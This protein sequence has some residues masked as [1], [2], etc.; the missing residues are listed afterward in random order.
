MDRAVLLIQCPDHKGIVA[1]ISNF[2]FGVDGNIIH[3]D[4]YSTDPEGGR[5]F[6][7]VEFDFDERRLSKETLESAFAPIAKDLEATW[8]IHYAS[9]PLRMG[10]LVSRYDH[11]LFEV[12]YRL[13][14]GDLHVEIPFVM[15]N[16]ADLADLVEGYGIPFHCVP[17]Q[18]GG[19]TEA[20][21]EMLRLIGDRTDFLVLARYM[22]ILTES[23]M[24]GYTKDIINI[25]HSFLPSF[26][27]ANPYR[28]AYERGVK[29]IGATAHYVTLDL[30][31]GPIIEQLV[32]HVS[33]RDNPDDLKRKGKNLEKIALVNA[34]QAHI[35]HRVIRYKNKTVVFEC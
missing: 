14:S 26:K 8:E 15:S 13:R 19:K 30:D 18:P 31:E 33:H 6:M 23:F 17:V 34:I 20:E 9:R 16:H 35:E 7:R 4:Q 11:C 24:N 28:Q 25:H 2:V 21:H 12:L 32:T 29:L 3:S 1:K 10:I 27:G 5:F 22:Q